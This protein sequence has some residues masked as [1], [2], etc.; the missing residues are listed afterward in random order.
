MLPLSPI[1]RKRPGFGQNDQRFARLT[2]TVTTGDDPAPLTA[3]IFTVALLFGFSFFT[4]NDGFVVV[5]VV[6]PTVTL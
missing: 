6:L 5:F 4:V 1:V 2:F 3:M